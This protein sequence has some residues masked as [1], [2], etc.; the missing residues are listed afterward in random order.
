M[1]VTI[2]ESQGHSLDFAGVERLSTIQDPPPAPP[3][4][5][6]QTHSC[7][8]ARGLGALIV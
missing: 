5:Y 1:S 2:P 7:V 4:L 3:N 8:A 6:L